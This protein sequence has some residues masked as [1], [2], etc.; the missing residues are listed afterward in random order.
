MLRNTSETY[1]LL[2]H[3]TSRSSTIEELNDALLFVSKIKSEVKNFIDELSNL[4]K[5]ENNLL[6]YN[7]ILEEDENKNN[8]LGVSNLGLNFKP[9]DEEG[10][11]SY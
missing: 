2:N 6:D 1:K 10:K 3:L 4:N 7:N 8:C 9:K 5:L 11:K